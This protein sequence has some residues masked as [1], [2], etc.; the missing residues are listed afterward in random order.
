MATER[1]Y[2]V[3]HGKPPIHARFP[4]GHSG[5]PKGRP[6][7]TK[8]LSTIV[9]RAID[10][11]VT[12]KE[13][14]RQRKITKREAMFTQL[15]NKAASGDHRSI[16]LLLNYLQQDQARSAGS[17]SEPTPMDTD[18]QQVLD[19]MIQRLAGETQPNGAEGDEGDEDERKPEDGSNEGDDEAD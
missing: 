17:N 5:N 18:D 1:D 19:G 9:N 2:E 10:E 15:A 8:N 4:K 7:G 3:G 13:N 14:G 16:Q 6:K 11:R 12:V